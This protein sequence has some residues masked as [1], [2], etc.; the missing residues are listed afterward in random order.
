MAAPA[1]AASIAA[2]AIC[3]GV[4]GMAGCLPT[5]SPA[6]V[7]AQVTMTSWFMARFS[8]G[9]ARP[10]PGKI[11]PRPGADNPAT[12]TNYRKP[13]LGGGPCRRLLPVLDVPE[14][15]S[16]VQLGDEVPDLLAQDRRGYVDISGRRI[17]VQELVARGIGKEGGT[18]IV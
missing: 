2:S 11:K 7:T 18:D 17:E 10:R 1:L 9:F 4:T 8:L 14:A 16:A 6:P 3:C 12:A 5:V 15:V 13:A